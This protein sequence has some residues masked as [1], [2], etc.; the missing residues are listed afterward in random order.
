MQ[1]AF[2]KFDWKG[3][4]QYGSTASDVQRALNDL[5]ILYP[6]LVNVTEKLAA[7]GV[8]KNYLVSFS[9]DLGDVPNLEEVGGLVTATITQLNDTTLNGKK[10]YLLINDVPT[11][12]FDLKDTAANVKSKY[13]FLFLFVFTSNFLRLDSIDHWSIVRN[14][15]SGLNFS[16][17]QNNHFCLIWLWIGMHVG[18]KYDQR[19]RFLWQMCPHFKQ[20]VL[21]FKLDSWFQLCK[22]KVQNKTD[23]WTGS[24]KI[25]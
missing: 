6:N 4:I 23:Y 13:F 14:Q 3:L 10:S 1:K 20:L 21:Q 12:L 16:S 9:V 17:E 8:S 7:D 25:V 22:K 11:N 2:W 19:D 18:S 15:M 5:P 24:S